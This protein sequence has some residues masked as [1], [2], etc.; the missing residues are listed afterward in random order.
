MK[1]SLW[2][3][4]NDLLIL[5]LSTVIDKSNTSKAC[6]KLIG[7]FWYYGWSGFGKLIK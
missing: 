1:A 3:F 6:F 7:L 2:I 4:V 5:S